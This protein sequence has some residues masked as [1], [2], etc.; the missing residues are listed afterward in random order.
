MWGKSGQ[1]S[2]FALRGL[3]IWFALQSGSC[4]ARQEL[5]EQ[6]QGQRKPRFRGFARAAFGQFDRA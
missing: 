4:R 2:R 6:F 3:R 1:Q 5:V